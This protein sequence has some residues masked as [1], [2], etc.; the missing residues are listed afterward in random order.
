MGKY[1]SQIKL[2]III[3]LSITPGCS[4]KEAPTAA[5]GAGE[6]WAYTGGTEKQIKY[7]ELEQINKSNVSQ[8]EVAW[9]YN[10]GDMAGNV[11][12][13]PLI[14][15]GMVYVTTPGQ[16]LIA[17]NAETGTELWS[18][19]PARQDEGFG[20]INRGIAYWSDGE[21][22]LIFYTSGSYL[23]A[24]DARTGKAKEAFGDGGRI[25]LNA[26]LIKPADQMGITAPAAPVIFKNLVIVGAMTW[27]APANVS[28]FNVATGEREWVFHT[29]PKPGEDGYDTWG[30][31]DFWKNGA[32]V[33]VWGGLSVDSENG[34]VFFAT[35]QPK[36]DFYRPENPG[37]QLYGNSIVALD[38]TTGK[39]E[40]HYQ[41]LY[42][43][44]WDLD[45]PCAPILFELDWKGERI[46]AVAQLSKTGNTFLFNRISGELLSEVEERP[47]PE[48]DLEGQYTHPVQPYVLWPEPFSKQ[49]FTE[50][51]LTDLNPEAQK[52]AK[53]WFDNKDTGWF[54]PPSEKGILYY[55]V[56]GGAEWGGGSYD[57]E[58]N[59]LFVNSN[60]LA[61][62]ITM[63][64]INEKET[65]AASR[66]LPGKQFYLQYA[67][68][69][70]H[71]ANKQGKDGL[72]ALTGLG[73]T[74]EVQEVVKIIRE[75]KNTMPAF[76]QIPEDEVQ[77]I[78][79][80]ILDLQGDEDESAGAAKPVYRAIDYTKFLDPE[81]YP[82]TKPPW[83][84]LNAIDL[85]TGKVK[86][87]VPLGEYEEL[88]KKGIAITGTENF[89]GSIVTKGGLVFVAATRDQK[90]RA[91]NKDTGE[92]LWETTLPYGGYAIPSTYEVNGKQY[93]VIPATGGG[94]LGTKTGDAYVAFALPDDKSTEDN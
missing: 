9:V 1:L 45:L 15:E 68:A 7:S 86:W 37:T 34:M 78:A 88:S 30:D 32:G 91:F 61:W 87:K 23:N 62:D 2:V 24:V 44:L 56:H 11:Q 8:L 52:F 63:R 92:L 72:P 79:Q 71:G 58:T 90:F 53:E 13:N 76:R 81:G 18:F 26:D 31:K 82:A 6:D 54:V 41:T 66:E 21:E 83:G 69:S 16:K 73:N 74:Y 19:D 93:V 77:L 75:G 14:V 33:N 39:K 64:N 49:E 89:G 47:V 20:G 36:D 48:S 70:C 42:N 43:D 25:D 40:W 84:T 50:D 51:Q 5:T 10:S 46:P 65:D 55:G 35:G 60:D 12:G 59:T 67:C 22:A 85:T 28:A 94:K 4:E 29:I 27:S 3:L 17:L 38:A 80:Y 57:P